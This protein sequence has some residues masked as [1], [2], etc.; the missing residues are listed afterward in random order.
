MTQGFN[1]FP[2]FRGL[3][4]TQIE[5]FVA[6]CD[7]TE[8]SA[9]TTL[10]EQG[11]HEERVYFIYEG[12]VSI[13]VKPHEG[14]EREL[15]TISAPAVLGEMEF[16]TGNPRSATVRVVKKARTLE[17]AAD[18]LKSRVSDGDPGALK[19]FYNVATVL[20]H[21]LAHM[22]TKL[23]ELEVTE[24]ETTADLSAFHRQL[25]EDWDI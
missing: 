16:L 25:Y 7:D 2:G 22:D 15:T 10:I 4:A 14:P 24:T 20:A 1:D 19:I 21:R 3:N 11:G 23:S 8:H 12:T 6:A 9:G 18:A 13:L 17:I 5:N